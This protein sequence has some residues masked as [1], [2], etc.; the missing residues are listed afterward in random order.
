MNGLVTDL[1]FALR[2]AR[3]SPLAYLAGFLS[4]AVALGLNLLLIT[5]ANAVLVRPLPVRA[6]PSCT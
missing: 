6:H 1:R 2:L 5:I 3:K 4:L